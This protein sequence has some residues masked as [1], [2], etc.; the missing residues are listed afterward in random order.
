VWRRRSDP[1][2]NLAGIGVIGGDRT[3]D[4]CGGWLVAIVLGKVDWAVVPTR[5]NLPASCYP[6]VGIVFGDPDCPIAGLNGGR[7]FAALDQP[8]DV[9][10]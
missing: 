10:L 2:A 3:I 7:S 5:R 4:G 1:R 9:P 8:I 6:S